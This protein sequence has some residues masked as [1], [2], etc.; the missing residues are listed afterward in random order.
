[1]KRNVDRMRYTKDMFS[2]WMCMLAIAFDAAYFVALYRSSALVSDYTTGLD[3]VYNIVFMMIVFLASERAKTYARNW[4]YVILALGALQF[5]RIFLL[6]AHFL[7]LGQL[8][9][10]LHLRVCVLLALSG[11]A[12]LVGGV[13]CFINA[14]TLLNHQKNTDEPQREGR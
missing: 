8:D 14:T 7:A 12:L 6:P 10:Q 5:F 2:Y 3:V 9:A 11:A 4:S 13:A 1:M